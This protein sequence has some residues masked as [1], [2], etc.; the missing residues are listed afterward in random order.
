[1][2]RAIAGIVI[3]CLLLLYVGMNGG[4]AQHAGHHHPPEHEMLHQKFYK[5]WM[6]PDDRRYSCCNDQDCAPVPAVRYSPH[7]GWEAQRAS[8]GKWLRI[9]QEKVE[10]DRDSPDGWA[11]MCSIGDTV[12]CFIS[13]IG[14]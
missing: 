2:L 14:G 4:L 1:M 13:G 12:F 5:S 8:D 3:A 6:R 7:T 10:Y 11:H 9:P